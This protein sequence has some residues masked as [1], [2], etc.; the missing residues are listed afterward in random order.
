MKPRPAPV[1]TM[2]AED[3]WP[4]LCRPGQTFGYRLWTVTHAW[5]RRFE[6][7][8]AP[9]GLTHMQFVLLAK[10]AWLT[11]QGEA[12]TQTR[13]AA[14]AHVDRMMGSK[15]LRTL[16]EKGF[17][18]RSAHP[19]DPRANSVSLTP[20]GVAVLTEAVPIHRATQQAFF[21]RLGQAGQAALAEQLDRLIDM[22]E[23]G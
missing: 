23:R 6:A 7:A 12:P 13:I 9:L 22:E 3:A 2:A 17:V 1:E 4:F 18:A 8:L 11:H 5:Q 14:Y 21:G 15:V 16:E 19:D 10:T 20:A